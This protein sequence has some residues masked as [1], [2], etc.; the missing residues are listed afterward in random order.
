MRIAMLL[1]AAA[2]AV[3]SPT[4]A[5]PGGASQPTVT[6]GVAPSTDMSLMI[7]AVKKGFLQKQGLNAQLQLFDSA[8]AALQG[9]VAGRAD[10]TNNTE[11]PQLAARAR[12]AKIVQVMTG[13]LSGKQNGLIVNSTKIRAP[14]DLAGKAVGVQRG[15]G[16][17]YHLAW[18]LQHNNIAPDKV[19]VK[20]M[21]APGQ[22]PAMARGDIDAFF[23]WEPFLSKAADT[24]PNAKVFSR[25]IDDGFVFAGNVA[26]REDMAKNHKDVA[27]KVVKGLIEA[28]DW[29]KANPMDAAKVADEVLHAPSLEQLIQQIQY[30]DWPGDFRRKVYNQE[31]SIA[32]W[33][34]GIG[35]FPAKD[36]KK[37]VDELIYP[38]IIKEAAPDRADF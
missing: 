20:Y 24:I 31:L 32:E 38:A 14:S 15:S 9:V 8:P 26:M 22:V 35:L 28:A 34:V 2:L 4:V 29:M 21:D 7:I 30:L 27:V 23:S 18:F 11:P 25:T 10:I 1:L 36:A 33:G 13:Y 16:A 37:L 3:A 19:S 5:Q 12:G 6:V 17:N